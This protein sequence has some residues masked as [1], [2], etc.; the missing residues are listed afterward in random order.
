MY[1]DPSINIESWG[2]NKDDSQFNWALEDGQIGQGCHYE[3]MSRSNERRLK[4]RRRQKWQAQSHDT[5]HRQLIGAL[6]CQV[7]GW[8][9]SK[10]RVGGPHHKRVLVAA[11]NN[12][13]YSVTKY[14]HIPI[15]HANTCSPM[16]QVSIDKLKNWTDREWEIMRVYIQL[17]S[18]NWSEPLNYRYSWWWWL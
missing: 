2:R 17:S 9:C 7:I 5:K 3:T 13:K 1:H 11:R 4:K 8:R 14:M 15:K 10:Q 12:E 18:F 16:W 6:P